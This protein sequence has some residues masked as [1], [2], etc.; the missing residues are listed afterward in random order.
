LQL[1]NRR[2]AFRAVGKLLHLKLFI[3]RQKYFFTSIESAISIEGHGCKLSSTFYTRSRS[4]S[5]FST[6]E[7]QKKEDI[8]MESSNTG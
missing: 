2:A 3:E 4:Y 7:Q 5:S 1:L 8:V 6:E